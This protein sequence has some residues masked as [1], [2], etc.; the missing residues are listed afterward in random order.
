MRRLRLHSPKYRRQGRLFEAKPQKNHSWLPKA[1]IL[2]PVLGDLQSGKVCVGFREPSR[3]L[4]TGLSSTALKNP[5][6]FHIIC[7]ASIHYLPV[8]KLLNKLCGEIQFDSVDS[9]SNAVRSGPGL[10]PMSGLVLG[11]GLDLGPGLWSEKSKMNLTGK[12]LQSV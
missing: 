4:W 10:G 11:F 6:V 5:A 8:F 7:I 9:D 2:K 1:V 12:L 3:L